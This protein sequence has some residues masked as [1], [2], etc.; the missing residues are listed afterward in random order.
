MLVIIGESASGKSSVARYLVNNF[1]FNNIVTY[2]TRE[3]RE[4]EVN[5]I[6]Y[7]FI[8]K[9]QFEHMSTLGSFAETAEYNGWRYAS[10]KSD[11]EDDSDNKV[12]VLTPHGIRQ[13]RKN[14]IDIYVV[15]IKIPRRDRL[16]KIL[17]RGDDIEEAYRR[18]LSDVGQFDGIEDEVDLVVENAGYKKSVKYVAYEIYHQYK[19][20]KGCDYSANNTDL[21]KI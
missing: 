8:N 21:G 11:Y 10:I 17:H 12:A 19:N 13:I 5:G 9:L 15:Y 16:I 20:K 3:P 2:T 18:S 7:H 14:G 4:G 6:D 1:G